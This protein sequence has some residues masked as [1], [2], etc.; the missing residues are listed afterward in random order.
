M[1]R[2]SFVDDV[3]LEVGRQLERIRAAQP[4]DLR[5]LEMYSGRG[6]IFS[7]KLNPYVATFVGVDHDGTCQAEFLR[8]TPKALFLK[9]DCHQLAASGVFGHQQ[10]SLVS[11][12][13]PLGVH[14][15]YC[16]HFE[17]LRFLPSLLAARAC[18]VFNVVPRPYNSTDPRLAPWL[19]RRE[20]FYGVNDATAIAIDFLERFYLATFNSLGFSIGDHSMVCRELDDGI[21]YFYGFVFS[22]EHG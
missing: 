14:G 19:G 11:I 5:G 16:E 15:S 9:G 7:H 3:A 17:A 8:S 13:N 18:V 6:A 20:K 10:F 1:A 22:V 2:V 12:D 21:P 4:D